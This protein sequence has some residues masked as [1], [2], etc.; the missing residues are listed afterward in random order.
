[1]DPHTGALA[2]LAQ[3][4]AANLLD[5]L[6][7]RALEGPPL[8]PA[9]PRP[10]R[11][12]AG[13]VEIAVRHHATAKGRTPVI[14]TLQEDR[15]DTHTVFSAVL[16]HTTRVAL[17]DGGYFGAAM[18]VD[19]DG[20]RLRGIGW[21]RLTVTARRTSP[22]VISSRRPTAPVMLQ[23]GLRKADGTPLFRL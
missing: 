7:D 1:M 4:S 13:T 18:V 12:P 22:C 11:A 10:G 17:P 8:S 21:S 14:L 2:W 19:P 3:G 15:G 23:L 9:W 5:R 6:V 20:R 16:G